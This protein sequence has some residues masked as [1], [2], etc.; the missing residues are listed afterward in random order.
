ME[1]EEIKKDVWE[2]AQKNSRQRIGGQNFAKNHGGKR[3][4]R[5]DREKNPARNQGG[6]YQGKKHGE[7]TWRKNIFSLKIIE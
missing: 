1:E 4:R 5:N 6:K 7:Q 3:C 2:N